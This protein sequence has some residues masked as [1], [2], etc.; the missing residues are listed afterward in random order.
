MTFNHYVNGS[1]VATQTYG[2]AAYS[3]ANNITLAMN[4][5]GSITNPTETI[6]AAYSIVR[7][8]NRTLSALEIKQ[9]FDA[10]RRRFGV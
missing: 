4:S 7:L 1:N 10:N 2:V 8:Y 3:T 6:K 5:N 9:N